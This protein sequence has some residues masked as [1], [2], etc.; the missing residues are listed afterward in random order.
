MLILLVEC[1][2]L[3]DPLSELTG[4]LEG[5]Q[6][7]GDELPALDGIHRLAAYAHCIGQLLLGHAHLGACHTDAILHVG[8]PV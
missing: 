8:P 5:Q 3:L 7:R 1:E 4:E 6:R 2:E